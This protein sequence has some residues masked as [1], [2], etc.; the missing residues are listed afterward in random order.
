MDDIEWEYQESEDLEVKFC[1][2]RVSFVCG[3]ILNC[4]WNRHMLLI[5]LLQVFFDGVFFFSEK[6][7]VLCEWLGD[8]S[9]TTL[10][11]YIHFFTSL[12]D[13][14]KVDATKHQTS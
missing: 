11:M 7:M 6:V 1:S 12:W 2:L 3:D 13:A 14:T 4:E 8:M 10:V 5:T 9:Q